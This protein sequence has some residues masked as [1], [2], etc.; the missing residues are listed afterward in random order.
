MRWIHVRSF[1][2]A[3]IFIQAVNPIRAEILSNDP[4]IEF[5]AGDSLALINDSSYHSRSSLSWQYG[6]VKNSPSKIANSLSLPDDLSKVKV[7]KFRRLT[8]LEVEQLIELHNPSLKAASIK[9]DQERSKLKAAISAWYPSVDMTANGLPQYL[10]ADSYRNP[11]FT[12]TPNTRSSQW[13]ADVSLKAKWNIIDP[14]RVPQIASA[15]D[16]FERARDSYLI[17]LRDVILKGS[18][19]FFELQRAD[20]AVVVGQKALKAS[21][22]MPILE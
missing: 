10:M 20:Q 2:L 5:A 17:A 3:G 1:L 7:N 6:E 21:L 12:T 19:K 22:L 16:G 18:I 4:S 13:K 9:I 11:D 15:R 14:A 8:L